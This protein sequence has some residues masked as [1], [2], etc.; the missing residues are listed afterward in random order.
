VSLVAGELLDAERRLVRIILA[1]TGTVVAIYLTANLAY[2][3]TMPVSA[4]PGK[5]VGQELMALLGGET[6]RRVMGAC[7]LASVLGALNG[8]TLTKARVAYALGRD[9]LSFAF[10]GR[11]H[12]RFATPYVS[13]LIQGG[14]AVA[15]VAALRRFDRLTNYFVLMEWLALLFAIAA[16]FVLRRKRPDAPRPYRTP[17]YPWVPLV[18]VAGTILGLAAILASSFAKGDYAPLVGLGIVAAGFPVYWIWRRKYNAPQS[19]GMT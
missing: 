17:G 4:M 5:V 1:G 13:I 14:V 16:V 19:G 2:L 6:G 15:L 18:F 9:G 11:A 12:P 7:I 10:L 8:I 3:A